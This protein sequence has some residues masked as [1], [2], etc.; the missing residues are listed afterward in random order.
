M[1]EKPR[2]SEEILSKNTLK[3]LLIFGILLA[4]SMVIVYFITI[5]GLYPVFP[6]NLIPGYLYYDETLLPP[7]VY[8]ILGVAL[9]EPLE[10]INVIRIIGK[11]LTMMMCTLFFCESFLVYQIRRPNKSLIK[12]LIEDRNKFMFVLIGFLFFVFIALIYIPGVQT[13]LAEELGINFM[14][15]FLTGLDW[16]VCFLIS[17]ICIISFEIVKY[18]ARKN[19]IMF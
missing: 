15:M 3:L 6:E 16:L 1:K 8:N 18:I 13:F 12:S 9:A 5:T 11:T 14:F 19:N 17:L 2:D 10:Q 4:I 7:E